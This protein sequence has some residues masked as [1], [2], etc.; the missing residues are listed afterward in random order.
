MDLATKSG[1]RVNHLDHFVLPV[2]DPD[3]AEKFYTDVMGARTLKRE[4]DSSVTRIFMK[5]GENHIGLFSQKAAMPKRERV[6]AYPRAAFAVPA[7]QFADL[8]DRI[9]RASPLVKPIDRETGMGCTWREGLAFVDSE[10]NLLEVSPQNGL[11]KT[12]LHHLHFDTTDVN[13][14]A[15]FYQNILA[16]EVRRD[17]DAAI[18]SL[19][20]DQEVVLNRV[21][22][23]SEVT[24]T[25]YR[26]R[27]Y[28]FHVTDENFS[29]IVE[30]LHRA[31]IEERDEHGEREGRRPGQLGTY[32]KEPSGFRLQITN[33][34][35]ATF[36]KHATQ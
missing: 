10:G 32:F 18:V 16:A 8:Q 17:G 26:G 22:A 27:H 33:E 31:G 28:A 7:D 24:Q 6:D 34:D 21:D 23:L 15:E 12:R 19:P 35:S 13:K 29:A 25:P 9:G 2:M 4:G 36:A 20:S 11:G 3:R 30:K 5:L 14:S 1:G